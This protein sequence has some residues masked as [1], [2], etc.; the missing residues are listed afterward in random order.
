M[1]T[2]AEKKRAGAETADDDVRVIRRAEAV[3]KNPDVA[4]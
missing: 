4:G 3:V 2:S 1:V